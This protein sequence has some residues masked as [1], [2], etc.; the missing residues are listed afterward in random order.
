MRAAPPIVPRTPMVQKT[1]W[2]GYINVAKRGILFNE[3][4]S[5]WVVPKFTCRVRRIGRHGSQAGQWIG[6][7][8]SDGS[9]T[10]EQEGTA[11]D[12]LFVK[13][14][15]LEAVTTIWWEMFPRPPHQYVGVVHP[16]DRIGAVTRYAGNNAFQL[17]I[18]DLNNGKYINTTQACPATCYLHTSEAVNELPGKGVAAGVTLTKFG[19]FPFYNFYNTIYNSFTRTDFYGYLNPTVYWGTTKT[20]IDDPSNHGRILDTIGPRYQGGRAFNVYWKHGF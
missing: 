10:V 9:H 12:C 20:I 2:S 7:D 15:T 3:V 6:I 16:G 5:Y 13:P 4:R 14:H 18:K 1:N 8:G 19:R 17:Y 11:V